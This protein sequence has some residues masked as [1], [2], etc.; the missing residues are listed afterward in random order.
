MGKVVKVLLLFISFFVCFNSVY[1]SNSKL[2]IYEQGSKI[3]YEPYYIN[4]DYFIKHLDMVPGKRFTD[5]LVLENNTH[6]TVTLYLKVVNDDRS[7]LEDELINNILMDVLLDGVKIYDGKARG[8]DYN[9]SGVDL[10][11]AIMLGELKKG[12]VKNLKV[13]T[14]LANFY[15]NSDN[16]STVDVKWTFY[17]QKEGDDEVIEVIDAPNTM[18]NTSFYIPLLA[19]GL[20]IFGIFI[21]LYV[22]FNEEEN[23]VR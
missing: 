17:V 4:D 18:N 6:G 21:V 9:N 8:L 20:M 23:E 14:K 3:Y 13:N 12:E 15:S 10:T 22:R 2:S 5:E 1:A 7:D 19:L 16:N 11:E